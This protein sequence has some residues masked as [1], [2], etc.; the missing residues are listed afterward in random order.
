MEIFRVKYLLPMLE[1]SAVHRETTEEVRITAIPFYMF[2]RNPE[3][4][5]VSKSLVIITIFSKTV[6]FLSHISFFFI[7]QWRYCIRIENLGGRSVQLRKRHWRIFNRS[8]TLMTVN[9]N[10]VMGTE[11]IIREGESYQYSSHV[12]LAAPEGH[13]W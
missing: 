7:F 1:L 4:Y 2:R 13:M 5:F 3:S 6:E 12:E 11:P 8:G 9:D 10:G